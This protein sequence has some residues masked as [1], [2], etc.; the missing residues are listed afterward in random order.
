MTANFA[1]APEPG[2][3]AGTT[4]SLLRSGASAR[5]RKFILEYVSNGFRGAPAAVA[6]GYSRKTAKS[7]AS[8]L[9]TFP[10]V[11]RQVAELKAQYFDSAEMGAKETLARLANL[12][13]SDIRQFVDDKGNQIP[14]HELDE[15]IARCVKRVKVLKTTHTKGEAVTE[16]EVTV[17]DIEARTPALAILA[18]HHRLVEE[19]PPAPPPAAALAPTDLIE[20]ARRT[21]FMLMRANSMIVETV[22]APPSEGRDSIDTK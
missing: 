17:V 3:G 14:I 16:T 19:P 15:D 8:E 20:L 4:S 5:R 22:V 13:R 7:I 6:A 2:G 12:A 10:D 1:E 9:L 11:A 21:A 18:R